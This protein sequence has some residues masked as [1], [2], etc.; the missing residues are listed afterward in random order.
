MYPEFLKQARA[1]GSKDAIRTLNLAKTAE[2][3]HAKLYTEALGKLAQLKGTKS[4]EFAV[5]PVCG[6]T[7]EKPDFEKCPSCFSPKEKFV[8]VS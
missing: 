2:I 4:R 1:D 3:E 6:F 7:S 8:K 5:C